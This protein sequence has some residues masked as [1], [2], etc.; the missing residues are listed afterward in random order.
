MQKTHFV[1]QSMCFGS[2][3]CKITCQVVCQY[4]QDIKE[5]LP[6]RYNIL[7][8]AALYPSTR[9]RLFS[10]FNVLNVFFSVYLRQQSDYREIFLKIN[11]CCQELLQI[12]INVAEKSWILKHTINQSDDC[13]TAN[14]Y[15]TNIRPFVV[16]RLYFTTLLLCNMIDLM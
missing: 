8:T 2:G 14:F 9:S 1:I 16:S 5:A 10:N 3:S 4:L 7:Y 13:L 6:R 12:K 15:N 11:Q